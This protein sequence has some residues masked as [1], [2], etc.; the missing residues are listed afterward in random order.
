MGQKNIFAQLIKRNLATAFL[1]QA[2]EKGATKDPF[3]AKFF[4][5]GRDFA[6]ASL[7]FD[8]QLCSLHFKMVFQHFGY[9]GV[10]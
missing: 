1:L 4:G 9:I 7:P 6:Y 3:E 10:G 8:Q 5:L 2:K